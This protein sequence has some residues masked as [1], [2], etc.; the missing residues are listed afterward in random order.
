MTGWSEGYSGIELPL[1]P[2]LNE[3][4]RYPA[5]WRYMAMM[6]DFSDGLFA[7]AFR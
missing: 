4:F 5:W 1:A 6:L 7:A 3:P 2:F